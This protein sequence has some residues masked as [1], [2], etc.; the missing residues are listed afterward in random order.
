MRFFLV[1][2]KI[3]FLTRRLFFTSAEIILQF[4][5]L[6]RAVRENKHFR[7]IGRALH[8]NGWGGWVRT[9]DHGIKTR[10]LTTWLRPKSA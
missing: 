9:N 5:Q 4:Q 1:F 3:M 7:E 6:L 8:E 10:C 2:L